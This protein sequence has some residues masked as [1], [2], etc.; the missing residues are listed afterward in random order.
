MAS[1][2]IP[3]AVRGKKAVDLSLFLL[4]HRF[5]GGDT[6]SLD[7]VETKAHAHEVQV[8]NYLR[9]TVDTML[10]KV[11]PKNCGR[12]NTKPSLSR[13]VFMIAETWNE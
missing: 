12:W 3:P 11:L 1:H 10:V 5:E 9:P 4:G 8:L 7:H 6:T 13:N 2:L